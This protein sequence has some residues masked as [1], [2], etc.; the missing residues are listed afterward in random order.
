MAKPTFGDALGRIVIS[1]IVWF[2]VSDIL[3]SMAQNDAVS[4]ILVHG[5]LLTIN[6]GTIYMITSMKYWNLGYMGGWIIGFL[7]LIDAGVITG[8]SLLAH[9]VAIFGWL[10]LYKL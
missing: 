4:S 8:F 10:Y 7:M 9:I 1:G 2:I 3:I 5:I 6:L